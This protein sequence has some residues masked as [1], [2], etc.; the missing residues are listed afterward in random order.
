MSNVSDLSIR[1]A[2]KST[3]NKLECLF[4]DFEKDRN[5]LEAEIIAIQKSCPHNDTEYHP[6]P[7]GNGD[8]HRSCKICGKEAKKLW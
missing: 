4:K 1:N 3:Q 7:S 2:I 6:D 8:S 5:K